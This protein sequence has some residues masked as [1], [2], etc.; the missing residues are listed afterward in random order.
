MRLEIGLVVGILFFCSW[1][2]YIVARMNSSA[3]PPA[4]AG[5]ESEA[6]RQVVEQHQQQQQPIGSD[7][8]FAGQQQHQQSNLQPA[9]Q[10]P[11]LL[12]TA[13]LAGPHWPAASQPASQW[14]QQQPQLRPLQEPEMDQQE[15]D[16]DPASDDGQAQDA[17][18]PQAAAAAAAEEEEEEEEG[19]EPEEEGGRPQ[20]HGREVVGRRSFSELEADF[21]ERDRNGRLVAANRHHLVNGHPVV[22]S[23]R[24][25]N[26]NRNRLAGPLK[27]AKRDRQLG[28]TGSVASEADDFDRQVAEIEAANS[29]LRQRS[30]PGAGGSGRLRPVQA[31]GSEPSEEEE[32]EERPAEDGASE[33]DGEPLGFRGSEADVVR[34]ERRVQADDEEEKLGEDEG[35]DKQVADGSPDVEPEEDKPSGQLLSG[36]AGPEGRVGGKWAGSG[37]PERKL[38]GERDGLI[39]R[40]RTSGPEAGPGGERHE[41]RLSET[42]SAQQWDDDSTSGT[43]DGSGGE[44]EAEAEARRLEGLS[45]ELLGRAHERRRRH[46]PAVVVGSGKGVPPAGSANGSTSSSLSGET[47]G[48]QMVAEPARSPSGGVNVSGPAQDV[49]GEEDISVEVLASPPVIVQQGQEQ[50]LAAGQ[51]PPVGQLGP[52]VSP[53]ASDSQKKKKVAKSKGK[54]KK[55]KRKGAKYKAAEAF[56]EKE[57]SKK[58]KGEFEAARRARVV[59]TRPAS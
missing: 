20:V 19:E 22:P 45:R 55:Y 44:L 17:E 12:L 43:S 21:K 50:P 27:D 53:F 38:A 58:K 46:A 32:E 7:N 56:A 51:A 30:E 16:E 33:G 39:K 36:A 25:R 29:R 23:A 37:R 48:Q 18:E 10:Q 14:Q 34:L 15:P 54:V 49:S 9:F 40:Q 35:G 41:H 2:A 8:L 4:R 28:E 6:G 11:A 47:G 1:C 13:P 59:S 26:R 42:L 5:A 24:N 57:L 52:I 3:G 31:S